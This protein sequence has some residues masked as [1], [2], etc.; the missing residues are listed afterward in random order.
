MVVDAEPHGF[1]EKKTPTLREQDAL[2]NVKPTTTLRE[3]VAA[4]GLDKVYE[5]HGRIDLVPLVR[6]STS[7]G[8]RVLDQHWTLTHHPIC[9]ARANVCLSVYR[10]PSR[11]TTRMVRSFPLL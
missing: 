8:T 6:A 9:T 3:D 1:D 7:Y 5:R 2:E 4:V 11:R 10:A